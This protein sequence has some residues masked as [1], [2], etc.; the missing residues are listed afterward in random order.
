MRTHAVSTAFASDDFDRF[1]RPSAD[2]E[3]AEVLLA[4]TPA[5]VEDL[6]VCFEVLALR[7]IARANALL[8]IMLDLGK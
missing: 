1:L 8:E 3:V 5:I 7:A 2:F 4:E 6:R